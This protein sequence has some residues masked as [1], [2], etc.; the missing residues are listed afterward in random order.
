MITVKDKMFQIEVVKC[1]IFLLKN[2]FFEVR[3]PH[4]NGL[5]I[6]QCF[7]YFFQIDL[8]HLEVLKTC[9]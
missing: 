8:R 6:Q 3:L 9:K 4:Q 1:E 5:L 2:L 7:Y